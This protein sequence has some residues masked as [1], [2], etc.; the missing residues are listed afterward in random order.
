[1]DTYTNQGIVTNMSTE[2]RSLSIDSCSSVSGNTAKYEGDFKGPGLD[3]DSGSVVSGG[4][5]GI[6]GQ[7]FRPRSP[8]SSVVSDSSRFLRD[9]SKR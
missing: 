6:D 1:M 7:F 4:S 9:R 3:L 8:G 2:H 5:S